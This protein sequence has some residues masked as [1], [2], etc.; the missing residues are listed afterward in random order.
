[1]TQPP[2][3]PRRLLRSR[4]DR[5]IGGV[6]GGLAQYLGLDA[7]LVRL[8]AVVLTVTLGGSPILVYILAL[9]LL[10]EG[11]QGDPP[12]PRPY[13]PLRPPSAAPGPSPRSPYAGAGDP[14]WGTEGAPWE[15]PEPQPRP[16]PPR[17][18]EP[19]GRA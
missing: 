14:I 12:S 5:Y 6:C 15:Q 1:M 17:P 13:P 10:P 19:R 11:D 18:D 8:L 16:Q 4:R 7:T 3:P 9:F 2:P